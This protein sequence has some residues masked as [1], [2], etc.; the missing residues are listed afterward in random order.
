MHAKTTVDDCRVLDV[1]EFHREGFLDESFIG[2]SGTSTWS[3]V[4]RVGADHHARR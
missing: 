2:Q 3:R 1:H 4:D